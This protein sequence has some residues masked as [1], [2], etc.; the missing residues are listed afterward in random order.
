MPSKSG[1]GVKIDDAPSVAKVEAKL[2]RDLAQGADARARSAGGGYGGPVVSAAHDASM[3]PWAPDVGY[4]VIA[5]DFDEKGVVSRVT[6]VDANGSR[7]EWQK[8]AD[9]IGKGLASKKLDVP[10]GASGLR[11]TVKIEAKLALPSG[12]TDPVSGPKVGTDGTQA[13]ASVAF[14]LSDIGQKPKRMVGVVVLSEA[15][16]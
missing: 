12:A 5:V 14:D 7:P 10:P 2:A 4:A 6:L 16:L 13:T 15:R 11:V 3:G 1:T 9:G 8:V